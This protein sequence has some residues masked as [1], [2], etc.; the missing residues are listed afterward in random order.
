MKKLH[1]EDLP[2]FYSSAS[3]VRAIISR[4]ISWTGRMGVMTNLYNILIQDLKERALGRT[5]TRW[6]IIL[7]LILKK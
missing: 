5:S 7:K 4:T 2:N 6:R 1:N 3:V